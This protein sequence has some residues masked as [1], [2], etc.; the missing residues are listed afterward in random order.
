MLAT[1][2]FILKQNFSKVIVRRG[3]ASRAPGRVAVVT[4]AATGIG[5]AIALQL[6][7]DGLD[8][9]LNDLP[10]AEHKLR[11]VS[12][13]ISQLGRKTCIY[14]GDVSV[15]S[16]VQRLVD[17]TV[18]NL[19]SVDVMI[20][21]AGVCQLKP[22]AQTTVE[23]WDKIFRVNAR[24]VFLCYKYGADQMVKQGRGGRII[25]AASVAGKKGCAGF[26]AYGASKFAVRGLTQAIAQEL[27]CHGITV[28]AYAP[29]LIETDMYDSIKHVVAPGDPANAVDVSK[30]INAMGFNGSTEDVAGLVSYLTSYEA[31]FI[32]GQS[33]AIDGGFVFD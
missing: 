18:Q 24:G 33:I 30:P 3:I 32:T 16:D 1:T 12:D 19:G 4:G 22:F 2:R 8:V 13:L 9:S 23:E 7:N 21:N 20:A 31:R 27:A 6:A 11:E 25:G 10:A 14:H 17:S 29:G 26:S 28:N 15:E 5:R